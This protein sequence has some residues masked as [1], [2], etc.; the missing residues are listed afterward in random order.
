MQVGGDCG[1]GC[2]YDGLIKRRYE[3]HE[4]QG[5]VSSVVLRR[6]M[7]EYFTYNGTKTVIVRNP[8]RTLG[9]SSSDSGSMGCLCLFE[10]AGSSS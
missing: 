7:W 2:C 3:K 4:L 1:D 10:E 5:F 9:S 6:E 8:E